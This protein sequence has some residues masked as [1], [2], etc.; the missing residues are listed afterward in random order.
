MNEKLVPGMVS[1]VIPTYQHAASIGACLDS[2]FAQTYDYYE[3]IVVNDGSTDNTLEVLNPYQNRIKII[4]QA[5][6]GPN[7]ARNRGL[8]EAQ[9]EFV[10]VCDADVIMQPSML[11]RM[12]KALRQHPEA[13]Y[14]YSAFTF[15]WKMFRGVPFDPERLKKRNFIHTTSLVRRLDHPGF[16]ETVA[17]L[18][19]W[20][21]WLTMLKRGK[22]GKL[23]R[24]PLFH[25]RVE[26]DS[27]I[28]SSW[29]PSFMYLVPWDRLP[30]R[31]RAIRKY[32]I[33]EAVI[34]QKHNL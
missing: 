13:S 25:V 21:V 29:M 26:G 30:W 27:R 6:A 24:D 14:V 22:I 12:V 15:G 32:Q 3:V 10:L 1:I 20:D 16:D 19:D 23:I 8:R 31:P 33:A 28:G 18:Q 9:G 2:I 34:K 7:P 17:R 4:N 11:E 5:N